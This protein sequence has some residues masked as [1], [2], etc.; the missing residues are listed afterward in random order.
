M[1]SD[2][3]VFYESLAAQ[4]RD[5]IARQ[6]WLI[7][8]LGEL[9]ES[10]TRMYSSKTVL[11]DLVPVSGH[12]ALQ[13]QAC[14]RLAE[15][16]AADFKR[17]GINY[18]L[19]AGNLLGAMRGGRFIPWDDDIDFGLL[20]PDFNRAVAYLS[21]NY[22]RG[23]FTARWSKRGGIF[24]VFFMNKVCLDLFPWDIYHKRMETSEEIAVFKEDYIEAMKFARQAEEKLVDVCRAKNPQVE[25]QDVDRPDYYEICMRMV[26]HGNEPDLENGDIFEGV[27]WQLR[28]EYVLGIFHNA[29]WRHEYILP[30][31]EVEFCGRKFM[32]PNN[33]D[34]WL[35]T[36]YG[37]WRALRP[38]FTRH[39]LV[40]FGYDELPIIEQFIAGK[41]V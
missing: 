21:E 32:A 20:R 2:V 24:K 14:V 12:L 19:S 7:E 13:Q 15:I 33:P 22:N 30:Y 4:M 18:F 6:N 37:D 3:K 29:V 35:T 40:A 28:K 39:K 8:R 27:D 36:R 38:D 31:G 9:Q 26:R 1:N 17:Q 23:L 16:V 34:A 41:I 11:E 5:V 10:V 25:L